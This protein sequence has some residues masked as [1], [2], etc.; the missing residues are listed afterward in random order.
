MLFVIQMKGVTEF[1]PNDETHKAFG[2]ALRS[3]SEAG[4]H[5]LAYDCEVSEDSMKMSS[6]V[7]VR[8]S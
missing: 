6:P 4:L 2:D 1:C 5:I 8:L 3:G 7:K